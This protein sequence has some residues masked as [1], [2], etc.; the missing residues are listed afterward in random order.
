MFSG[1]LALHYC[2]L[3]PRL[4]PIHAR[5]HPSAPGLLGIHLCQILQGQGELRPP[6]THTQ[7]YDVSY[8]DCHH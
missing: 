5:P 6:P 3:L 4:T 1:H 8:V 7:N 2:H